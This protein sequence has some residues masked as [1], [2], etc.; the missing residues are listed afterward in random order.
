M[1][2]LRAT[3]WNL[4]KEATAMKRSFVLMLIPMLALMCLPAVAAEPDGGNASW[5]GTWKNF[6]FKSSGPIACKAVAIAENTWE[7]KFTGLFHGDPF[8]YTITFQAI[9]KQGVTNLQGAAKLDGD[10]YEWVGQVEGAAFRGKFRSLK[11]Y[12]GEFNMRAS[13]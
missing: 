2:A 6:K 9:E 5:Q 10:R 12:Y 8:E 4:F 1:F 11:G 13:R 7:G 3:A